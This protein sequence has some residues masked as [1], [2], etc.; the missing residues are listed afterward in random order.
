MHVT[1]P[2]SELFEAVIGRVISFVEDKAILGRG[3]K[4]QI[5][6]NTT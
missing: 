2:S 5:H 6:K 4:A 3:D 1:A